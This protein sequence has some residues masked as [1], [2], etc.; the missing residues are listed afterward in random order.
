MIKRYESRPATGVY[1][2]LLVWFND[3]GR[4]SNPNCDGLLSTPNQSTNYYCWMPKNKL[5]MLGFTVLV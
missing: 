5:G 3:R 4:R 1:L 2:A